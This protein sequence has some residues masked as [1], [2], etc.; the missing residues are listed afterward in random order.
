M[1]SASGNAGGSPT[2]GGSPLSPSSTQIPVP[3][4]TSQ[5]PAAGGNPPVTDSM[6]TTATT[7]SNPTSN[8]AAVDGRNQGDAP[9]QPNDGAPSL[10]PELTVEP[11]LEPSVT[12]T[13]EP[14]AAP[15]PDPTTE[16]TAEPTPS[17][18]AEPTT[19]T[20]PDP[21]LSINTSPKTPNP[22]TEPTAQPSADMT[23]DSTPTA[24]VTSIPT[25]QQDPSPTPNS[26]P[27]P[28]LLPSSVGSST[29]SPSACTPPFVSTESEYAVTFNGDLSSVPDSNLT[30]AF[31]SA[32]ETL[33]QDE[34]TPWL[35]N[36][37]VQSRSVGAGS[38]RR[39]QQE[40]TTLVIFLTNS[41]HPTDVVFLGTTVRETAF[42]EA[43]TISLDTPGVSAA[44]I[45]FQSQQPSVTPGN[46]SGSPTTVTPKQDSRKSFCLSH[47]RQS[48]KAPHCYPG[49]SPVFPPPDIQLVVRL[50]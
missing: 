1:P 40:S 23:P 2:G 22:T 20:T 48:N 15:T 29:S 50:Q 46:P 26:S 14:T 10:A 47:H 39:L 18:T 37:V 11:T 45:T 7:A 42:L 41:T 33:P 27:E 31:K 49:K 6:P 4:S 43:F 16:P 30:T 19:E 12:T 34:C 32:H 28:S 9:S 13:S 5:S 8:P 24:S 3:P 36:V 21:T 17:P 38:G 44:S 25:T 35:D